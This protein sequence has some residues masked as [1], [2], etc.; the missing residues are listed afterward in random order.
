[1]LAKFVSEVRP[2]ITK[3]GSGHL[4]SSQG[5]YFNLKVSRRQRL[6][7]TGKVPGR[8]AYQKRSD[9]DKKRLGTGSAPDTNASGTESAG[10]R[11]MRGP[12]GR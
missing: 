3:L 1:V 8:E 10:Q 6:V 4:P 5:Q 9:Q 2:F 12:V 11:N 7:N